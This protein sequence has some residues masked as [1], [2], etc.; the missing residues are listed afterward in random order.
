VEGVQQHHAEADKLYFAGNVHDIETGN[1]LLV[2]SKAA[3]K[4]PDADR[5][6][7]SSYGF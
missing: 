3:E 6:Q 2:E 4:E 7:A 5:G 1:R